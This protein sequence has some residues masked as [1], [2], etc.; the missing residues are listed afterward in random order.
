LGKAKSS[1][2]LDLPLSG[3]VTWTGWRLPAEMRLEQWRRAGELLGE[4]EHAVAWWIGNWWNYGER[5]YGERKAIVAAEG[6][7]EA[8]REAAE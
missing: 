8:D 6:G 2:Q 1:E 7:N 3:E 4:I 5:C